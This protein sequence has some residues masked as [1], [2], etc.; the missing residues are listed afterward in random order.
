MTTK[1][2]RFSI[3]H[4]LLLTVAIAMVSALIASFG[5]QFLWASRH[6]FVQRYQALTEIDNSSVTSDCELSTCEFNG[7]SFAVPTSLIGTARITRATSTDVWLVF[8]DATRKLHIPL[9]TKDLRTLMASRPKELKKLSSTQLL[10]L[11]VSAASDDFSFAMGRGEL[12]I[13]EWAIETRKLLG[14]EVQNMDRYSRISGPSV[15][16]ILI[17]A[18]PAAIDSSGRLRSILFCESADHQRFGTIWFGDLRQVE[19]GWI[20]SVAKSVAFTSG[21]WLAP[22]ELSR[23]NDAEILS[24][25]SVSG[26]QT[27]VQ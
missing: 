26:L 19:A 16:A 23:L 12:R 7:L 8:E 18:D 11:S 15:D 21:D 5:S 1:R 3:R 13:H 17:S 2:F 24:R 4:L 25:I 14:F 10:A 22:T 27:K 20:D 6:V 9:I